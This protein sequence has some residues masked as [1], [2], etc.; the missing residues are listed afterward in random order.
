MSKNHGTNQ[1]DDLGIIGE[2]LTNIFE[3]NKI[4]FKIE[5]KDLFFSTGIVPEWANKSQIK[6]RWTKVFYII[7]EQEVIIIKSGNE[8]IVDLADPTAD[9]EQA[10]LKHRFEGLDPQEAENTISIKNKVALRRNGK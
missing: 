8:Y 5:D 9:L 6:F 7:E 1:A 10:V 4:Y 3:R 2:L